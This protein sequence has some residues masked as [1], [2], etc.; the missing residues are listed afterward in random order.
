M[1]AIDTDDLSAQFVSQYRDNVFC[2]KQKVLSCDIQVIVFSAFAYVQPFQM[3]LK[4][5]K[6]LLEATVLQM[7]GNAKAMPYFNDV[8]VL[9]SLFGRQPWDS[10]KCIIM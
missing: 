2:N 9:D 1:P 10:L 4:Y 7:T 6:I 8:P 3:V 5:A